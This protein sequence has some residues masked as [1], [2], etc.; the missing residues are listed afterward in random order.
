MP[1]TQKLGPNQVGKIDLVHRG[2]ELQGQTNHFVLVDGAISVWDARRPAP[3]EVGHLRRAPDTDHPLENLQT[4]PGSLQ[5]EATWQLVLGHVRDR[6]GK[7]TNTF[8]MRVK[9]HGEDSGV[10]ARIHDHVGSSGG[11]SGIDRVVLHEVIDVPRERSWAEGP[12]GIS[13]AAGRKMYDLTFREMLRHLFIKSPDIA[14]TTAGV[15]RK[16]TP[17]VHGTGP[18]KGSKGESC[19]NRLLGGLDHWRRKARSRRNAPN[20][21]RSTYVL[22]DAGGRHGSPHLQ[23]PH[24]ICLGQSLVHVPREVLG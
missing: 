18:P 6:L 14:I 4:S 5:R 23:S 22:Q 19:R 7:Q 8:S 1:P 21:D 2:Q 15:L 3:L 9:L 12:L 24:L 13:R 17:R 16:D 11:R 10:G 20:I